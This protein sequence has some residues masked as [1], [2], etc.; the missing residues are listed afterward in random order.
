MKNENE[1]LNKSNPGGFLVVDDMSI[2]IIVTSEML[3]S[4][5]LPVDSAESGA[6][7]IEMIEKGNVYDI[8]F[9]DHMMPDMNGIEATKIIRGKGYTGCIVM[10]TANASE[11][12]EKLYAQGGFEMIISKPID[13][14]QMDEVVRKYTE[15]L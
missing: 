4:Y 3:L 6:E 14:A 8:I 11:E 2:N 9:M 1:N 13:A 15:N 12:N 7:A 10:L 5:G